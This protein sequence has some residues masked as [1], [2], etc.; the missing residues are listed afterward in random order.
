M[1]NYGIR[2]KFTGLTNTNIFK[3]NIC[4]LIFCSGPGH[5]I[6][7]KTCSCG[8]ESAM[9]VNGTCTC[10]EGYLEFGDS[11]IMCNGTTSYLD[12]GGLC[13]CREGAH[14]SSDKLTCTCDEDWMAS[15]V[16]LTL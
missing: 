3:D 11:C 15:K 5:D 9:A 7:N 10:N 2:L 6:V 8:Q 16:W 1:L 14:L 4:G 13:S 12:N